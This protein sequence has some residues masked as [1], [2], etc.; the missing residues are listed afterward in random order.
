[1]RS[2]R[3]MTDA[4]LTCPL[5]GTAVPASASACRGCH[6]PI[7]DVRRHAGDDSKRRTRSWTSA[8]GV[9]L[10]GVALYAGA[11]AW[12][13]RQLPAA[14]PFVVPAAAAGLVAHG[15]KGRPW[16]GLLAFVVLVVALPFMLAP[17]LGAGAFS[18]LADWFDD[19]QW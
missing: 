5:C 15:V 3:P 11:V 18:D 9:R 6:L 8:I 14:L 13:A 12:C 16:L 7:A 10:V 4:G 19:P 2:V 17:A 1:M